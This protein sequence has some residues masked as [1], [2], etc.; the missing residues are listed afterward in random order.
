MHQ[1]SIEDPSNTQRRAVTESL[2]LI[3][4]LKPSLFLISVGKDEGKEQAGASSAG[5]HQGV[6]DEGRWKDQGGDP[7]V[8]LD[9]HQALGS[10]T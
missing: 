9:Q 1:N 6:R 10:I 7:G 4:A 8:E 2:S 3:V 5:N